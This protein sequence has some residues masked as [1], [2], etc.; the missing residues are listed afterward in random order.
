MAGDV[1]EHVF[2]AGTA[3]AA[4]AAA[5]VGRRGG[6]GRVREAGAMAGVLADELGE[7]RFG[8]GHEEA[9]L[10]GAGDVQ[11][12]GDGEGVIREVLLVEGV[13]GAHPP[14]D[15]VVQAGRRVLVAGGAGGVGLERS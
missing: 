8:A 3:A 9:A 11:G 7:G 15:A 14:G 13:A 12:H 6:M 10:Q 1:H 2:K 5:T 4:A